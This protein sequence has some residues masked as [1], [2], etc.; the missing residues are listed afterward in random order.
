MK[1]K[2]VYGILTLFLFLSLLI[3]GGVID[4]EVNP[5]EYEVSAIVTEISKDKTFFR[6]FTGEEWVVKD[7][8]YAK[9]GVYILTMSDNGTKRKHDDI[10]LD[11]K[12]K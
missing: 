8:T 6:D 10:I 1:A 4:T 7:K 2:I 11:I 3:I 9:D 12:H 5:K